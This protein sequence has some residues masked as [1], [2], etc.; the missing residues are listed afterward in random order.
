MNVNIQRNATTHEISNWEASGAASI[1][2]SFETQVGGARG[3]FILIIKLA[4]T[5]VVHARSSAPAPP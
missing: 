2:K 4:M 3:H 1:S 5:L